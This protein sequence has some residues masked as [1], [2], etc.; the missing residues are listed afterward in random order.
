MVI[1]APAL[2][3][4]RQGATVLPGGTGTGAPGVGSALGAVPARGTSAGAL[5]VG[6]APCAVLTGFTGAGAG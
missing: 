5:G 2:V 6:A 1:L 4:L 3:P